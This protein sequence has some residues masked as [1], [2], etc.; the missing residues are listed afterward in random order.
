MTWCLAMLAKDFESVCISSQICPKILI[1][2]F[3]GTRGFLP[4]AGFKD[5]IIASTCH[6]PNKHKTYLLEIQ[7]CYNLVL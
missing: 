1:A 2:S 5:V 4:G 7:V 3:D 6:R